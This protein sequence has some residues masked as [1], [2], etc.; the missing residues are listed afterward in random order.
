MET[1]IKNIV[2]RNFNHIFSFFL[3][4][5]I[6][7]VNLFP[8]DYVLTVGDVAQFINLQENFNSSFYLWTN[9][10]FG[11]GTY[12]LLF[13]AMG[14]YLLFY[15]FSIMGISYSLQLSVQLFL[16]LFLSYLSFYLAMGLL[17]RKKNKLICTL[18][19]L[20]YAVN[21]FTLAEFTGLWGYSH[22]HLLYIFLPLFIAFFINFIASNK[23][24]R[25]ILWY[26]LLVLVMSMSFVNPSFILALF[27]YLFL[28]MI[29]L[30]LTKYIKLN[31]KFFIRVILFFTIFC[32]ILS[33]V[34]LPTIIATPSFISA[35]STNIEAWLKWQSVPIINIFQF[36]HDTRTSYYF[37]YNNPYPFLNHIIWI[38]GISLFSYFSLFIYLTLIKK[39]HDEL[40]RLSTA[41]A[42]LVL[43][44]LFFGHKVGPPLGQINLF[45]FQLPLLNSL[46]SS[47]KLL[48]FIPFSLFFGIYLGL[49]NVKNIKKWAI[50]LFF[51]LILP[52]P[53]WI[54]K[55]QQNVSLALKNQNNFKE[56]TYRS[57]VKIPDDYYLVADYINNDPDDFKIQS[58][59][60]NLINSEGWVNYPRWG[61][62]G[63]DI[64][65]YLFNKPIISPN[66]R[67][68]NR[69]WFYSLSF[70]KQDYGPNDSWIISFSPMLNIKYI[71]FHLDVDQKF[72][73]PTHRR[74]KWLR[75]NGYIIK[76]QRFPNLILYKIN[77]DFFLPPLYSPDRVFILDGSD[78]AKD[79][80]S[81][82]NILLTQNMSLKS[83]ILF[84]NINPNIQELFDKKDFYI[85]QLTDPSI[86]LS[87][88]DINEQTI[89]YLKINPTKYHVRA[90]N[91]TED[92]L[93]TLSEHYDANWKLYP[94]Q[95][96]KT[97]PGMS[98][99]LARSGKYLK[100]SSIFET[101][102]SRS[103]EEHYHL[104]SNGYSNT[105]FISK[106]YLADNF[107]NNLNLNSDGSYDIEVTIESYPQKLYYIGLII[108]LVSFILI[109][110]YLAQKQDKDEHER[111]ILLKAET[112][113][114]RNNKQR[115]KPS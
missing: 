45:L 14:Y 70:Q 38:F 28:L 110:I 53:F 43:C 101:F 59:P 109:T 23:L 27:I 98:M 15:L 115:Y 52:L 68:Y 77:E 51:P 86:N 47:D 40:K 46:R 78:I 29:G 54:G 89:E 81:I 57:L 19:S 36:I 44:L 62:V 111:S 35:I 103:I 66:I 63:K 73:L 74:I 94:V 58:L 102:F 85:K 93:L 88:L 10:N 41:L 61:L 20:L 55:F 12:N 26:P 13:P 99:E 95:S 31:L 75:D 76:V 48:L 8:K 104:M 84:K 64:T 1:K 83:V 7:Y 24:P 107:S 22:Q 50:I 72:I 71:L 2:L 96:K 5:F 32:L 105:W 25:N 65:Q 34:L 67:F 56:E 100:K 87:M 37:P 92:F 16:F 33:F 112:R 79:I 39:K 60:Y 82:P 69:D 91:V 21:L 18:I 114:S 11:F 108:S 49:L 97:G 4:L 106:Q 6:T 30:L 42:F 80:R 17:F 90:H 113:R 3:V 9:Y